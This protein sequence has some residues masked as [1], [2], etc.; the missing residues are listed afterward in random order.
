MSKSEKELGI[1]KS[2]EAVPV[3]RNTGIDG[4]LK[5][6]INGKPIPVRIQKDFETLDDT[7][8]ALDNSTQAKKSEVKIIIQTN[9]T[10]GLFRLDTN[11]IILPSNELT[12]KKKLQRIIMYINNGG[13]MQKIEQL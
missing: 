11:A 7:I 4:F 8:R 13:D 12:I 9:D 1:L 2:I 10:R 5:Q 6:Q 3:Q